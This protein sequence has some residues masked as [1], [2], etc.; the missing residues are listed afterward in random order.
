MYIHIYVYST[1]VAL[2]CTLSRSTC[3]DEKG[4]SSRALVPPGVHE[5]EYVCMGMYVYMYGYVCIYV[6]VCFIC[7]ICRRTL[8]LPGAQE[9]EYVCMY[10]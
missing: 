7:S 6:C 1:E 10:A 2:T 9:P 5:P 8:V 3:T 4:V